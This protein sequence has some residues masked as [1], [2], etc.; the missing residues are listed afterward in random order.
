M[1]KRT[2]E[3]YR[4]QETSP[5]K[6]VFEEMLQ[7]YQLK[8]KFSEKTLIQEWGQLMGKTVATRT[9]SLSI[10]KKVLY[11]KLVSGPLKKELMMNKTKVM[12]IIKDKFGAEVIQ[13][14]IFM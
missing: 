1:K 12:Q 3:S 8:D 7:A 10:Q 5:L 9:T 4:K 6:E 11:V 14:I 2:A 13:D